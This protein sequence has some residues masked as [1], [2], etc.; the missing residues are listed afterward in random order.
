MSPKFRRV[1]T[2]AAAAAATLL[3]AAPALAHPSFNPNTITAGEKHTLDFVIPH[4]CVPGGGAPAEGQQ[5]SPTIALSVKIPTDQVASISP[6]EL[7]GW[8]TTPQ[9]TQ[10]T[11]SEPINPTTDPI[12]FQIDIELLP[13]ADGVV[14]FTVAQDCEEG[15][16]LWIA[17]EGE[18]GDPAAL[19]YTGD[20]VGTT[21]HGDGGDHSMTEDGEAV[22]GEHDDDAMAEGEHAVDGEHAASEGAAPLDGGLVILVVLLLAGGLTAI[23]KMD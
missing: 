9:A 15:S 11:W 13:D 20:A 16:T 5:A 23:M 4:G 18:D 19:L 8:S 3:V 14:Y 17:K 2:A 21:D 7:E 1:T 12:V 22:D 10:W 6:F